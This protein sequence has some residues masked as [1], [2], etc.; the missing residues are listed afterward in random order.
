MHDTFQLRRVG[1]RLSPHFKGVFAANQVPWSRL[2]GGEWSVIMNTDPISRPGQ[3]WVAA[4][5]KGGRCFFFDSY[6]KR[7]AFYQPRLWRPL[8]RCRAN[9]KDYQQDDSTVCSDYALFFVKT[10][11]RSPD[12][13]GFD[14]ARIDRHFDESDDP[15]NDEH[16]HAVVHPDPESRI[17]RRGDGSLEGRRSSTRRPR[18]VGHRRDTYRLGRIDHEQKPIVES[19]LHV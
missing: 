8:A 6:G 9:D 18:L 15:G 5:R 17:A 11:H 2:T 16:V 4:G 12:E 1:R 14:F 3:H 19:D 13:G 10:L 7:P